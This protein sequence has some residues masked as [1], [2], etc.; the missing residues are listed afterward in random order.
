MSDDII[1]LESD[2]Q[3]IDDLGPVDYLVVE[4]PVGT[5]T[6][7]GEMAGQLADLVAAG[8]IRLLDLMVI[9]KDEEGSIDAFEVDDIEGLDD[10]RGLETEIAE[11]LAAEDVV[12][13][14]A[15]MENGS[16][17]G[18]LVW[19]NAWAAPFASATR[20]AGGQLV[21]TGRIPIQAIAAS[22][23]AEIHDSTEGE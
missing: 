12:H 22:I 5:S 14:A 19:E 3:S 16:T 8:T 6:F 18:V 4:F 2:D 13:L 11:I 23:E 15:A 20:R 10:L 17:A 21:A 7:N 9:H 1:D